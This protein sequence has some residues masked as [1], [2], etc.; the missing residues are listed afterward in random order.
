MTQTIAAPVLTVPDLPP[1]YVPRARLIAQLDAATRAPLT[2]VTAPAGWGKT[3]T[4]ASWARA[5]AAAGHVWWLTLGSGAE[6]DFAER[7]TRI[8]VAADPAAARAID[9]SSGDPDVGAGPTEPPTGGEDRALRRLITAVDAL[10]TSV[11]VVVDDIEK[12][13]DPVAMADF[14]RLVRHGLGRLHLVLSSR[15]DPTL[16]L[17]RWRVNGALTELRATDL[18][19]TIDETG[20]LLAAYDVRLPSAAAYELHAVTEGWPAGLRLAAL[21]MRG[22]PEPARVFADSGAYATAVGE[23]LAGE[24]VDQLPA[25]LRQLVLETSVATQLTAGLAEAITGREDGARALADLK[26][27]NAFITRCAGSGGWY[28]YHPLFAR[29]RYAEL[30]RRAPD[31][32]A[33]L[34]RRA[35]AWHAAYGLPAEAIRHALIAGDWDLAGEVLDRHWADVIGGVRYRRHPELPPAP[36]EGRAG[37]PRLLLAFA[38]ERLQCG[39][40]DGLRG[41]L[42]L[43]DRATARAGGE[44][45]PTPRRA[46]LMCA[47]EIAEARLGGDQRRV[48]TAAMRLLPAATHQRPGPPTG[49]PTGPQTGSAGPVPSRRAG[50]EPGQHRSTGGGQH[51]EEAFALAALAIGTARMRLGDLRGAAEPLTDALLVAQRAGMAQTQIGAASQLTVLESLR[52]RLRSAARLARQALLTADRFGVTGACDLGWARVGLANVYY[53]W[54]RAAEA[55]RLLDEALDLAADD[56]DLLLSAAILR[57]KLRAAGGRIAAGLEALFGGRSDL[58]GA[59]L[60][61]AVLRAAALTEAELRVAAGDLNAGRRLLTERAGMEIYPAW[62]AAIEASIALA[63]GKTPAAAAAVG[64]YLAPTDASSLAYTVHAGLVTALAGRAL[65]DRDR[66]MRGLEVALDLAETEGYRHPFSAGGHTVRDLLANFAPVLPVYH[67]IAAELSAGLPDP[68]ALAARSLA[69]VAGGLG[70]MV[71]PLTDRELTVLRYLQGT[72]SNVE[73]ASTL[74]VSVNTVKTHIKNIYRKLHAGRRREAVERAREL[75]LL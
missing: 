57:A 24:V 50:P 28:T 29:T 70:P 40:T 17:Y 69:P 5:G 31:R 61:P 39:D 52:G 51:A 9:E 4:L 34:H 44:S 21:A 43:L 64:P 13:T 10:E 49:P 33:E 46:L 3:V 47:F 20:Q 45:D 25:D 35:G 41:C 16:P 26:R 48:L 53:E 11:V 63:D 58:A 60:S 54:D 55:G 42:R 7:L 71:D 14:E 27:A 22:D 62:A 18:S 72:L 68:G 66:I 12:I 19:F 30:Q 2:L 15:T 65:G 37:D 73:I 6:A 1:G 38:T 36:A 74:Y 23:F 59:A 67:P 75:R 32:I 56:A 8:L